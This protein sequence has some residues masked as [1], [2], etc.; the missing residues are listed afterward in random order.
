MKAYKNEYEI[1]KILIKK[2]EEMGFI[3]LSSFTDVNPI[4]NFEGFENKNGQIIT[5]Q[6]SVLSVFHDLNSDQI[7]D[8]SQ[9]VGY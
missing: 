8:V 3:N 2:L 9:F 7:I 6:I 1:T 4:K 5:I